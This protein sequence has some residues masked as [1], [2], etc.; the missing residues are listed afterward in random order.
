MNQS[1]IRIINNNFRI[2]VVGNHIDYVTINQYLF[3]FC[4]YIVQIEKAHDKTV[5]FNIFLRFLSYLVKKKFNNLYKIC[6]YI[7]CCIYI[8]FE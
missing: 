2:K 8:L 5:K 3:K 6:I 4:W 7:F 1:L